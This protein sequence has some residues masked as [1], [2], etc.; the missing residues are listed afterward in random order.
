VAMFSEHDSNTSSFT[1]AGSFGRFVKRGVL[2]G[3]SYFI[4]VSVLDAFLNIM[5]WKRSS[6]VTY[7]MLC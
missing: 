6:T 4:N 3:F 5:Q 7:N 1:R 2:N